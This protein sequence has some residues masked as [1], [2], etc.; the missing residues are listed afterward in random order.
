MTGDDHSVGR[1]IEA[2]VSFVVSGVSQ[3]DTQGGSGRE[4]V[5]GSGRQVGIKFA[6]KDA[7]VVI[8]GRSAEEGSV[9][10]GRPKRLG[11]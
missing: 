8:G 9:G 11:G 1:E 10:C 5:G 6:P 2:A 3:E 7:N 4:F